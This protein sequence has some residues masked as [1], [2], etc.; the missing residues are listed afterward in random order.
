MKDRVLPFDGLI[1]LSD[2]AFCLPFNPLNCIAP[3]VIILLCLTP[4]D[5]TGLG[6]GTGTPRLKWQ[7][8]LLYYLLC[9]APK[10]FSRQGRS[11]AI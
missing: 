8:A 10:D 5:F 1:T 7:C 2:H 6:E 3:Y 11:A 9:L 4:D